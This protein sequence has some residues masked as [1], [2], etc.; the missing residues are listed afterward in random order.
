MTEDFDDVV[1]E[2]YEEG[3]RYDAGQTE[4]TRRRRNLSPDAGALLSLVVEAMGAQRVLEIGTSNGLSTLWLARAVQRSGGRVVSVDVDPE[5]QRAA[6]AN[7]GRAG[8]AERVELRCA[9]GG[10][11]LRELPDAGQDVVFLDSERGEYAGWWP[12]PVRVLRPGGL[13]A[14]D[15]VL[16]HPDE[17]AAFSALVAAHP[18]L[19]STVSPTGKGQLL[20]VKRT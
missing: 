14:V 8:L 11:V 18:Q 16:S 7:L 2:L 12:H 15:N 9:D 19:S 1:R 6:A 3:V 10:R 20:A 13:L 4:R 17:V 5:G